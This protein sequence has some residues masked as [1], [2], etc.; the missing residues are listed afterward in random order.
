[1]LN[2]RPP[3]ISEITPIISN[4]E[5]SILYNKNYYIIIFF[6]I[7]NKSDISKIYFNRSCLRKFIRNYYWKRFIF[8]NLFCK[9]SEN[10]FSCESKLH[11]FYERFRLPAY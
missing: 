7:E 5:L 6:F 3:S 1:M 2:R 8:R 4:I 9:N 11:K 10:T